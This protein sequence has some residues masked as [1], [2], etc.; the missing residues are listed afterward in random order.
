MCTKGLFRVSVIQDSRPRM[1]QQGRSLSLKPERYVCGLLS[2]DEVDND[3][4]INRHH[5]S[6]NL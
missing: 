6:R 4:I 1:R 2:A 3:I 5:L